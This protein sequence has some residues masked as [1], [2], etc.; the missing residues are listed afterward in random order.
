[1]PQIAGYSDTSILSGGFG[2]RAT[3]IEPESKEGRGSDP[4]YRDAI[5]FDPAV[6]TAHLGLGEQPAQLAQHPDR[7][8]RVP[9]QRRARNPGSLVRRE[10]SAIVLEN[11]QIVSSN[12]SI[13]GVAVDNIDLPRRERLILDRGQ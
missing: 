12:E 13:G 4:I 8:R 3:P 11:H 9:H 1:M 6:Q 10:K 5:H 7:A 2:G